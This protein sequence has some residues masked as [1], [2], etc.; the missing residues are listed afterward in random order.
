[1]MGWGVVVLLLSVALI[2]GVWFGS[3]LGLLGEKKIGV[4]L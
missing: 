3:L 1:M 4:V 2:V